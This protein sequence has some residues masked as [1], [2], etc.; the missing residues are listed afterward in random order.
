MG[1]IMVVLRVRVM[2]SVMVM[3]VMVGVEGGCVKW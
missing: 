1:E 2:R 3:V